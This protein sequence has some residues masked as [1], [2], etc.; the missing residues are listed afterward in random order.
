MAIRLAS[1]DDTGAI[2]ALFRGRI[3]VWQRLNAQ[4]RVEDM[5]YEALTLVERWLHGGAWM[6]IETG[7]IFLNHLL[8]GAGIPLVATDD[9]GYVTGYAEAYHGVEAEPY[10]SSLHL[11]HL[12]TNTVYDAVD[13]L[14]ALLARAKAL[15]ASKLTINRVGQDF[16]L[17]EGYTCTSLSH[18]RRYTVGARQGQVFYRSVEHSDA[19]PAQI[20]G[21]MM[22]VGR[23]TSARH[24]WE[25]HM[26]RLWEA[27]PRG[28]KM[29]RQKLAAA[30]QD[31][32]VVVEQDM[33][34]P[35]S[36]AVYLWAAKP[37][38]AQTIMAIRDWSHREGYRT[39]KLAM[40]DDAAKVLGAD[41]EVDA[42]AQETCAVVRE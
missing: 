39:L 30:G 20:S 25:T 29:H 2:S 41:A 3:G 40:T 1:L 13:L 22:P 27:L 12:L 32:Y 26:P 35:R 15:K 21:W 33:Y 14:D 9:D 18:L 6:S 23:L 37:V 34:D 10:G 42:F 17:P 38:T 19:N 5:P 8:S 28:R 4:G 16:T 11:E 36:A 31:S 7:A 24:Q